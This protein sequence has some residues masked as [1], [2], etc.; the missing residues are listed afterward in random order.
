MSRQAL[1]QFRDLVL[2]DQ[3]LQQQLRD[4]PDRAVFINCLVALAAERGYDVT[5]EDIETALRAARR[6]WLE[7]WI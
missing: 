2:E 5:H 4:T 3:A 7:R 6:A 1:E